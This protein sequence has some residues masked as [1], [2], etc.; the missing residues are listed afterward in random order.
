MLQISKQPCAEDKTLTLNHYFFSLL[1]LNKILYIYT[2]MCI[3][4]VKLK[5]PKPKPNLQLLQLNLKMKNVQSFSSLY[6]FLHLSGLNIKFL[7]CT[8]VGGIKCQNAR[9]IIGYT[10]LQT[11]AELHKL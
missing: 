5:P 2:H 4:G 9:V 11:N 6:Y 10:H 7:P 8:L 1:L 3:L